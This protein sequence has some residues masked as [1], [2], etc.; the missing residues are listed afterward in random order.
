MAVWYAGM[1]DMGQEWMR[2]VCN[3]YREWGRTGER[4]GVKLYVMCT[5][6]MCRAY[7]MEDGGGLEG[8]GGGWWG[9]VV[10]GSVGT[11]AKAEGCCEGSSWVICGSLGHK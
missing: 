11:D 9:V 8:V 3:A 6:C 7:S 10:S 5:G 2:V 4:W 1:W